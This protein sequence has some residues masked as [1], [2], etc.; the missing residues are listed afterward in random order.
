[1]L[2]CS[3]RM[4][5]P[6]WTSFQNACCI[7]Q[8]RNSSLIFEAYVRFD[9]ALRYPPPLA[10]NTF[11]LANSFSIDRSICRILFPS[12]CI[13]VNMAID[14]TPSF[15]L[16]Q[17]LA[18]FSAALLP[19]TVEAAFPIQ[20]KGLSSWLFLVVDS[21]IE[22]ASRIALNGFSSFAVVSMFIVVYL[23]HSMEIT[24]PVLLLLVFRCWCIFH[25]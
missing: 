1:M 23:L 22:L 24:L 13:S 20:M 8:S 5:H 2:N 11:E 15:K 18:H 3:R 16:N 25:Y 12:T 6:S 19:A 14:S 4:D 21:S 7:N 17:V 10:Y 9:S